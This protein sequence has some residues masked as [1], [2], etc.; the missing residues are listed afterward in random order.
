MTPLARFALVALVLAA[1]ACS[2]KSNTCTADGGTTFNVGAANY[3]SGCNSEGCY[4][5]L[6]V[7]PGNWSCVLCT[8]DADA[9]DATDSDADAD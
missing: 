7:A 8:Q 6:C 5:Y 3:L 9:A 1:C 2:S 4:A